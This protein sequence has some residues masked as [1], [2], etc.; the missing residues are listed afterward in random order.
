MVLHKFTNYNIKV[1]IDKFI[2]SL[3]FVFILLCKL[4]NETFVVNVPSFC[5]QEK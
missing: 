5:R 3:L 2:N 1:Y 4:N